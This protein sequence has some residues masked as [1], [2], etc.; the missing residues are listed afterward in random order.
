MM[1]TL[2]LMESLSEIGRRLDHAA[3]IF[4]GLDFDGT[5]TPIRPRPDDVVLDAH[6]RETLR[7]L[8]RVP[9]VTVMIVSGRGLA[10]VAM[11]VGLPELIYA[12][13]HGLEIRGPGNEFVEPSASALAAPLRGLTLRLEALL[14][15]VPGALVESKGLT[16]SVHDRNVPE[17]RRQDIERIVREAVPGD[18]GPFIVR[19]GHRVWEVRPRLDWNKGHA[20]GWILE[21]LAGPSHRVEFYF[22]DDRTDEDAF[23]ALPAGVT[24]KV[25]PS[26]ST[27][28]QYRTGGPEDVGRFLDWLLARS[29]AE[30]AQVG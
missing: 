22:G 15:D 1:G 18:S 30:G 10:D 6:V 24:V 17:N 25:G 16:T 19:P 20:V 21:R 13:N 3:E 23:A 12:G 4:L 8:S 28:A 29:R 27:R 2:D 9:G 26:E 14:S 7:G 11:R 5:L